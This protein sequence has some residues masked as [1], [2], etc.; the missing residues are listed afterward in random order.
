ML[1]TIRTAALVGVEACPVQIEVDVS[2]GLPMFTVVGL[3]DASIRESRDRVRSAIRNSGF[4]FPAHRITVNLAPADVRK[5]GA[6]LDL[7][8]AVGILAAQGTI[9]PDAVAD[10]VIVGELSLD[11]SIQPT[12][13]VLPVAV[14]ARREGARRLVLPAPNAGEAAVV[15]PSGVIPVDSLADAVEALRGDRKPAPIPPTPAAPPFEYPDLADVAGQLLARRAIEIAAAGGHN[16]LM[17]GPPGAGKTMMARRMAGILPPP[18]FDEALAATAI[19]SVAGLLPAGSGLLAVRPFRAPH[20]TVTAVALTGGGLHPRP[21]E[22]SL[23]HTGVL[24]LDEMFEFGRHA[25]EVLRQPLEEGVV[26]VTRAARTATF[27]ARFILVGAANP[28]PCGFAG[29]ATRECRCSP[30]QV[31]RYVGQL[32]GPLRDRLDLGVEV[33][34]V[35]PDLL[36]EAGGGEASA[37]VRRRVVAARARQR[38]RGGAIN[39]MLT[40]AETRRICALDRAGVRLLSAAADRLG[41]TARGFDRVRRVARTIADLG[42][43]DRIEADHL[44][45]AIQFRLPR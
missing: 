28:C 26:T 21:G 4:E 8:I 3:P 19:H 36:G 29:D 43:S 27:P 18:T 32:S 16:L 1:A 45:E 24:F 5:V 42:E 2:F 38:E 39:G 44:S 37:P 40:P 17:T 31:A 14:T 30:L 20:H 12:R 35:P 6:A 9:R 25:L 7:P 10:T 33:P 13:G 41:L 22:V 11:G 34:R 23:A 15:L